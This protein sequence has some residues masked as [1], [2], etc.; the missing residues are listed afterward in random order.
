MIRDMEIEEVEMKENVF[1]DHHLGH[2]IE[3]IETLEAPKWI[4]HL[5]KGRIM[6]SYTDNGRIKWNTSSSVM[7][8]LKI[9][10][11][12]LVV[13]EFTDYALN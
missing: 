6:L 11:I 1:G 5:S 3:L 4:C 2:M 13:F 8:M 10:K 9:K 12:E 7:T